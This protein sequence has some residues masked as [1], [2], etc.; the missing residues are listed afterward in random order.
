MQGVSVSSGRRRH[1]HARDCKWQARR[2]GPGADTADQRFGGTARGCPLS[3]S[4]AV[5]RCARA[6]VCVRRPR[7]PKWTWP[8]VVGSAFGPGAVGGNRRFGGMACGS[9]LPARVGGRPGT[10][11]TRLVSLPGSVACEPRGCLCPAAA[12]TSMH[13]TAGGR[14]GPRSRRRRG[15]PSLR[16]QNPPVRSPR[17]LGT[18]CKRRGCLWRSA[19]GRCAPDGVRVGCVPGGSSAGPP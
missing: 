5:G 1:H 7:S 8:Q 16:W 17:S 4:H 6:I 2:L 14:L 18:P 3:A 9:P 15:R 19:A 11:G 10:P 13:A 12:I